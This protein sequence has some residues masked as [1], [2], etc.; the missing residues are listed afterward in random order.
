MGKNTLLT[1]PRRHSGMATS[2][3]MTPT[4]LPRPVSSPPR[5]LSRARTSRQSSGRSRRAATVKEALQRE[6]IAADLATKAAK[7]EDAIV[8][9]GP[10]PKTVMALITDSS[11]KTDANAL[12]AARAAALSANVAMKTQ[13]DFHDFVAHKK[14]WKKHYDDLFKKKV[15]ELKAAK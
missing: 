5:R 10:V 11:G 13:D 4:R 14:Q 15:A 6:E 9:G 12:D 3:R 8:T 2:P 7:M 1:L